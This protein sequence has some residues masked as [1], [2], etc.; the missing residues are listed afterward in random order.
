[1]AMAVCGGGR[2]E[3][4]EVVAASKA[5]HGGEGREASRRG[6][7]GGRHRVW[8]RGGEMQE[9]EDKPDRWARAVGDRESGRGR[10]IWVLRTTENWVAWGKK[11]RRKGAGR[12]VR[13]REKEKW[14]GPK[15][16]R[17]RGRGKRKGQ[18]NYMFA[19]NF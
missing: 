14:V 19:L 2:R 9:V 18:S 16:N 6:D 5:G 4:E 7:S 8:R 17:E 13:Q 15:G 1:M 12:L 3:A 10:R 11:K